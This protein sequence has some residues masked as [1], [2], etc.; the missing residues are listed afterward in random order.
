MCDIL[1]SQPN[2]TMEFGIC[3]WNFPF[4][5]KLSTSTND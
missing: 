4:T 3:N 5:R 2:A 1:T